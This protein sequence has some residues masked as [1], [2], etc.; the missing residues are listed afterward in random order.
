MWSTNQCQS[1]EFALVNVCVASAKTL[2]AVGL[3]RAVPTV[4]VSVTQPGV[5]DAAAVGTGEPVG[6][7]GAGCLGGAIPLITAV[8]A[9]VVPI[10]APTPGYT[11]LVGTG[12]CRGVAGGV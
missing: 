12:E 5:R 4:I 7:A 10:A 8:K 2:T 6:R 9:V 1:H 3:V 11:S